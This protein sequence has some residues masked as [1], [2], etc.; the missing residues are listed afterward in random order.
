MRRMG[1][2]SHG[3]HEWPE[4][5]CFTVAL[6]V[7]LRFYLWCFP[8]LICAERLDLQTM[9]KPACLLTVSHLCCCVHSGARTL[10]IAEFSS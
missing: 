2:A 7:A 9:R 4:K 3:G 10:E 8:M 1:V 6:L 5:A